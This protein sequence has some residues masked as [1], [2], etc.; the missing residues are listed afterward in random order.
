MK[1]FWLF[2]IILSKTYNAIFYIFVYL[3]CRFTTKK[4][5]PRYWRRRKSYFFSFD[6]LASLKILTRKVRIYIGG[7]ESPTFT[8]SNSEEES[9]IKFYFLLR[10]YLINYYFNFF[11]RKYPFFNCIY[12][13]NKIRILWFLNAFLIYY[14]AI[15][16]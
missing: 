12:N 10:H 7:G 14:Y 2:S 6:Y 11:L 8:T 16:N 3:K 5:Q 1:I 15:I 9:K 13:Y 4:C